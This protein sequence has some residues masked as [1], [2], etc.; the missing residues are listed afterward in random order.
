PRAAPPGRWLGGAA[1]GRVEDLA[2]PPP[3]DRGRLLDGFPVLLARCDR[4]RKD[5]LIGPVLTGEVAGLVLLRPA[6]LDANLAGE[7]HA[8]ELLEADRA[9]CTRLRRNIVRLESERRVENGPQP[10]A[11]DL[12]RL[13]MA[14]RGA[15]QQHVF[16]ELAPL[17][18]AIGESEFADEHFS[19]ALRRARQHA[20][21]ADSTGTDVKDERCDGVARDQ[22]HGGGFGV[23]IGAHLSISSFK[24]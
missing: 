20:V 23:V 15:F 16:E 13:G 19:V 4:R 5:V 7:G 12:A 8:L 9:S 10:A 22:L 17:M 1:A 24:F 6:L 3:L 11:A 18:R 21:L 14:V 2:A